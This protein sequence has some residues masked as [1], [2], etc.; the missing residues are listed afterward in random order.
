MELT[1]KK[2]N[3]DEFLVK[4]DELGYAIGDVLPN[5]WTLNLTDVTRLLNEMLSEKHLKVKQE[6]VTT[7][8]NLAVQVKTILQDRD[9]Q[10]SASLDTILDSNNQVEYM[11]NWWQWRINCQL[12]LIEVISGFYEKANVED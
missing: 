12:A 6:T 4:V 2:E 11:L 8:D 9:L 7:S 10:V 1:G 5:S 3:F